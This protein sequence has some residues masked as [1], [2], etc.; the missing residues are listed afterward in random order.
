MLRESKIVGSYPPVCQMVRYSIVIVLLLRSEFGRTL[1]KIEVDPWIV[2]SGAILP[3]QVSLGSHDQ[4]VPRNWSFICSARILEK[5]RSI[6]LAKTSSF[7][8]KDLVSKCGTSVAVS[9][10]LTKEASISPRIS[11][12]TALALHGRWLSV[13]RFTSHI[14]LSSSSSVSA[15][16]SSGSSSSTSSS[17]LVFSELIELYVGL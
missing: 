7:A 4:T 13:F 2:E 16:E 17:S 14:E 6:V 1:G 9:V 8:S 5:S 15:S 10:F 12:S 11:S 3:K